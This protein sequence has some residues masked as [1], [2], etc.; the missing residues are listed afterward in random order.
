MT[1]VRTTTA[2]FLVPDPP[3]A[4]RD[5][6]GPEHGGHYRM[7]HLPHAP[8]VLAAV[9]S[10]DPTD[11]RPQFRCHCTAGAARCCEHANAEDLLCEPCRRWCR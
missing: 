1:P 2:D 10:L 5:G 11:G 3:Q 7:R 8:E 9:C 6:T 4:D